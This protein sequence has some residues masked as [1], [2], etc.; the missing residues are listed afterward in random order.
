M[1][2]MWTTFSL[3]EGHRSME[4]HAKGPSFKPCLLQEG[5]GDHPLVREDKAG[6]VLAKHYFLCS[7]IHVT[8][9]CHE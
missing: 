5:L 6:K 8:P 2:K 3:E 4:E 1:K 7:C 9:T